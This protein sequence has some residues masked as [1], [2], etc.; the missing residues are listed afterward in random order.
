[1]KISH[2]DLVFGHTLKIPH[3]D[4]VFGFGISL[5]SLT[6]FA[7][8]GKVWRFIWGNSRTNKKLL[9]KNGFFKILNPPRANVVFDWYYITLITLIFA[10]L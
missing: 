7:Q 1:M 6:N 2:K 10:Y 4:L 5:L 8:K 9:I 3:K